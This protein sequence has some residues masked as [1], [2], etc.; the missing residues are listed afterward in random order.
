MFSD[1]YGLSRTIL[2]L[3][4]DWILALVTIKNTSATRWFTGLTLYFLAL[5]WRKQYNKIIYRQ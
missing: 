2:I 4:S 1:T 3:A 5:F